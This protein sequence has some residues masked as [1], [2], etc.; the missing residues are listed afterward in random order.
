[1]VQLSV[2]DER[3]LQKEL[4]SFGILS[5]WFGGIF[6]GITAVTQILHQ[7]IQPPWTRPLILVMELILLIMIIGSILFLAVNYQWPLY[8]LGSGYLLHSPTL[9]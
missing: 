5:V 8:R 9:E 7:T 3:Y 2:E 1:M 4:P 6:V